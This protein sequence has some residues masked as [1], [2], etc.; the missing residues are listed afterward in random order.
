MLRH[1]NQSQLVWIMQFILFWYIKS[2]QSRINICRMKIVSIIDSGGYIIILQ[3]VFPKHLVFSDILNST[4]PKDCTSWFKACDS[5][6]QRVLAYHICDLLALYRCVSNDGL[7][8]AN[9][10]NFTTL[11]A[12][13]VVLWDLLEG[14]IPCWDSDSACQNNLLWFGFEETES[15]LRLTWYSPSCH[16]AHNLFTLGWVLVT[17]FYQ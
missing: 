12:S 3:M 14:G 4:S 8:F 7:P 9:K 16:Y 1:P 6:Q 11:I 13:V 17:G 2:R 15:Q 5:S 10:A